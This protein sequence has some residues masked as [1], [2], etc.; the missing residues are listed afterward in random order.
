MPV[1]PRSWVPLTV[2]LLATSA[3]ALGTV[4]LWRSSPYLTAVVAFVFLL[5]GGFAIRYPRN[6]VAH[7]LLF[8]GV[9]GLFIGSGIALVL[10]N[11][12]V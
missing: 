10:H 3:S 12:A 9:L 1:A 8:G 6:A 7:S 4:Y 11:Q 2:L 5:G